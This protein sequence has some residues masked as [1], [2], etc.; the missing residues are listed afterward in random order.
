MSTR[1]V[2]DFD[3]TE[4]NQEA[5]EDDAGTAGL[6]RATVRKVFEGDLV[7]RSEAHLLMYQVDPTD[8]TGGA[9]YVA[10]EVVTGVLLGRSGSFVLQHWGLMGEGPPRTGGSV[11]PGSGTGE[12]L[13]LTGAVEIAVSE[14]GRH[15]LTLEFSLE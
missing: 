7:G 13:G 12:L 6:A 2:S 10:S 9:G 1:A 5:Y 3:V 11:I 15:T 14:E 4:W 8:P